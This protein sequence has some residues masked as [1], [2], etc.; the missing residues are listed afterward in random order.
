MNLKLK[1][2][3][4]INASVPEL[5]IFYIHFAQIGTEMANR[6][7]NHLWFVIY[8]DLC[9]NIKKLHREMT[10]LLRQEGRQLV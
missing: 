5:E 1:C 4:C 7:S 2:K 3:E 9:L 10:I 8:L 6:G